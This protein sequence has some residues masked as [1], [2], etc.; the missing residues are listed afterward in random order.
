MVNRSSLWVF[1]DAL[2]R[3]DTVRFSDMIFVLHAFQK[4]STKGIATPKKK[5]TSSGS[6][7][8]LLNET[9]ERGKTNHEK[10]KQN[11][12]DRRQRQR[13]CRS[14]LCQP[15]AGAI[16]S[17]PHAANLPH[18]QAAWS[19]PSGGWSDPWH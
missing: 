1:K 2:R 3:I 12:C 4:Q 14:R 5:S 6:G 9:T 10:E 8:R 17:S 16:E 15:G 19:D 13:L 11:S 18:D 7:L